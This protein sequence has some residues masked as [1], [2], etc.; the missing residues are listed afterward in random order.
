MSPEEHIEI[1][2]S[3]PDRRTC[4]RNRFILFNF[5]GPDL[6]IEEDVAE[7]AEAVELVPCS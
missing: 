6:V 2:T 4:E 3:L 5:I 7:S 1:A